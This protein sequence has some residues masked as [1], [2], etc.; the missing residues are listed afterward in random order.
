MRR[1]FVDT[2]AWYAIVDA[3]DA[4]H[5][6]S[7]ASFRGLSRTR[8][9]LVTTGLVLAELHRLILH[10]SHPAAAIEAVR[11]VAATPRVELVHPDGADLDA[12]ME[13]IDRFADQAFTLTDACSFAVM[14]R[15]GVRRAFAHD[16]DFA[17]AGFELIG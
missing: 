6:S 3:S 12:A 13:W 2:S 14:E 17:V 10:R 9:V 8:A 7:V 1:V 11:R 5:D 16:A 15:L 4:R